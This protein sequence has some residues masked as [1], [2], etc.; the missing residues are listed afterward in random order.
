MNHLPS[1]RAY[2][3]ATIVDNTIYL[4][5]GGAIYLTFISYLSHIY[6]TFI[7][8][9]LVSMTSTKSSHGIHPPSPGS[10]LE[11]LLLG[12]KTMQL[13]PFQ[14]RSSILVV[15]TNVV[16][17]FEKKYKISNFPGKHKDPT[18]SMSLTQ[19]LINNHL[20]QLS[21][22]LCL[23]SVDVQCTL[24]IDWIHLKL[25]NPKLEFPR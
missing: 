15:R 19:T 5:G 10:R 9:E 21:R 16:L 24:C 3:R 25:R 13:L 12:D 4:T 18:L 11:T 1:P 22:N 8:K 23:D 20:S 6:L 7:W 14:A 17:M 2:L